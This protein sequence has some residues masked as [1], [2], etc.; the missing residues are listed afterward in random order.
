M[1]R[2]ASHLAGI[3]IERTRVDAKLKASLQAETAARNQAEHAS[4]VKDEFLATLSHELRTPLNAILG[5]SRL[6]QADAFEPA[7]LGKGLVVIE[8]SARAQTQIIDDLLDMSAIL[9]GKIRLQP[10]HFDIAGLARSTV[11]LMQPT[12]QAR[13]IRLELDAPL[14]GSLWFFGDAGRLQQVLT[15]L[16]SNALKFTA[17]EGD[18]RVSLRWKSSACACAYAILASA[19]PPTSCRMCST[20][21]V[22]PMPAP[23]AAWADWGWDC[24]F[25]AS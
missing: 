22:R 21:S 24:R 12:A 14:Q 16:I 7:K 10:E 1:A 6:M 20:A 2:S 17:P 9:S 13:Q 3:V 5:W 8:R 4:R 18:V 23:P 19:L 15:N 11:E 25:R